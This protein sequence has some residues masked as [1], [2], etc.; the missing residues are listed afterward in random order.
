MYKDLGITVL[1]LRDL[2]ASTTLPGLFQ[3]RILP[4]LK[5]NPIH[6]LSRQ[7]SRDSNGGVEIRGIL[8]HE[9]QRRSRAPTMGR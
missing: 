9:G 8:E 5:R 4:L 3:N 7:L 1:H 2:N 6:I